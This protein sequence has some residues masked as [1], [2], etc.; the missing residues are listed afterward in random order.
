MISVNDV[1]NSAY[2]PLRENGG[3]IWGYSGGVWTSEA[4]KAATRE[5]TV[6]WGSRWIG[7]RCWDC[8]G[9]WVWIF[10]LYGEKIYH[11][12]NTIWRSYCST[13]GKI[14]NGKKESGEAILPGS[15]VFLCDKT[16][17]RHHIGVYV[18]GG[19]CIEAKGTYYGVVTSDISHWDEWGELSCVDYS[20]E[21]VVIETAESIRPGSK[22]EAVRRLQ[23]DLNSIGYNSGTPDGIYGVKTTAAVREFQTYYGL[24]VDGIAGEQ[25]LGKIDEILGRCKEDCETEL[26]IMVNNALTMA[27]QLVTM[28]TEIKKQL[29]GGE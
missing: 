20:N 10:G 28:L 6:K 19:K 22:G 14:V 26:A 2:I 4:Q 18:G 16:G 23:E 29:G 15:A 12:S 5:Q 7:R 11:G 1:V 9:L 17:N 21:L 27:N 3:Y 13:K 8:S 25:T 24:A